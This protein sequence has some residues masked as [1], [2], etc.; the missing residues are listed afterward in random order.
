MLLVARDA[1]RLEAVASELSRP[2]RVDARILPADLSLDDEIERV[3]LALEAERGAGVL[4]NNAGFGTKGRLHEIDTD[5]QVRM[6]RLHAL[7]PMR[8]TRAVLPAMVGARAGWVINVSSVAGFMHGPGNVNYCATKAYLTRFTQG[9]DTELHG[10]GVVVQA[11][12]PGF[13]HTE[14]HARMA[15]DKTTVWEPLWMDAERV[16]DESIAAADAGGPVVFIPGI[17]NR[18]IAMLV[19]VLPHGVMRFGRQ[20]TRRVD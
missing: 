17:R 18:L 3:A 10:T 1:A 20:I 2:H 5:T 4:V 6:V 11:L 7:A 9:L 13:T 8:L 12:C 15:M 16:V 14:F 19:R